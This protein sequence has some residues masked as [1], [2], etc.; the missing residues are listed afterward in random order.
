[1]NLTRAKRKG[2]STSSLICDIGV[3]MNLSINVMSEVARIT[4]LQMVHLDRD[5]SR[6]ECCHN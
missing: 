3:I 4:P 1:M 2:R 6:K 5:M